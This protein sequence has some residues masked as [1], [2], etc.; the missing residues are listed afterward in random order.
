M[1]DTAD[2]HE[3]VVAIVKMRSMAETLAW[4]RGAGFEVRGIFPDAELTWFVYALDAARR[5]TLAVILGALVALAI[6]TPSQR[7]TLY[8]VAGLVLMAA[9]LGLL[10][11]EP[12]RHGIGAA[13]S[14]V[15]GA[16]AIGAG[17][18]LRSR[19]PQEVPP[20]H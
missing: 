17:M 20:E 6:G 7:A 3:Q 9:G 5:L 10:V 8:V 2:V 12:E 14:V 11:A 4:Y 18:F 13:A 16:G 15:A 1:S 19:G